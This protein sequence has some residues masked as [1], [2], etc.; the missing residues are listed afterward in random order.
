MIRTTI[1]MILC[2]F[3]LVGVSEQVFAQKIPYT[4]ANRYFVKN[5]IMDGE[6]AYPKITSQEQFDKLFGMGTVMGKDGKPTPI[7]FSNQFAIA[8]IDSE[9]NRKV[10]LKP[11]GLFKNDGAITFSYIKSVA[12]SES[13]YTTRNCIILIVDKKHKEEVK[14]EK[15]SKTNLIPFKVAKRYF[16]NNTV[17]AGLMEISMISTEAEFNKYFGM[18]AVMGEDGIPT[19]ID[20][21]KEFVIAVINESTE[22]I[23]EIKFHSLTKNDGD[24]TLNYSVINNQPGNSYRNCLIVIIDNKYKGDIRFSRSN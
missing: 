1:L 22:N 24:T 7:D 11:S 5:T 16:V 19:S 8:V 18:A 12:D 14:I 21:S 9:S 10:S 6:L 13:S 15:I 3:L 4:V 20:F 23:H 17:A 2:A